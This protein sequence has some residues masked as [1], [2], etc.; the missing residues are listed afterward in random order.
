MKKFFLLLILL[1]LVL[2]CAGATKPVLQELPKDK[3]S[4]VKINGVTLRVIAVG[5]TKDWSEVEIAISNETGD[6]LDFDV[7]KIFVTNEKGYDLIPLNAH[8]INERVQRKTGKWVNPLSLGAIASGIAAI[9][10]PSSHDRLNL[11]KAALVLAGGGVT[12]ELAK[13][14]TAEADKQR[15]DDLLLKSYKVPHGLQLGGLLYYR[16]TETLTGV[17]AFIKIKGAEEFFHIGL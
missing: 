3:P 11:A 9:V 12:S 16:S 7:S 4:A 8:E 17:K 5:H 6:P 2:G 1:S 14:Q 15:K 10:M 13:K